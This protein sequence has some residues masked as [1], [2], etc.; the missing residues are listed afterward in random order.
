LV[1]SPGLL[2]PPLELGLGHKA[3]PIPALSCRPFLNGEGTTY[4]LGRM[5]MTFKTTADA[6]WNAANAV[7]EAV[8]PPGSGAG[9]HRHLTYD[10]TLSSA[11]ATMTF[12]STARCL[13]MLDTGRPD[14]SRFRGSKSRRGKVRTRVPSCKRRAVEER[15]LFFVPLAVARGGLLLAEAV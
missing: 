4:Q 12:A 2:L 3:R 5:S 11:K 14:A 7:C 8:E 15:S 13:T 1:I 9:H 6:G 10:E